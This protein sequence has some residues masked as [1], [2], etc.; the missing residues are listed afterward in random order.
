MS[1]DKCQVPHP[2]FLQP[3][4]YGWEAKEETLYC[5]ACST[6]LV[7][8]NEKGA[9]G[10]IHTEYTEGDEWCYVG[11]HSSKPIP[12]DDR[13]IRTKKI[14]YLCIEQVGYEEGDDFQDLVN[15]ELSAEKQAD[16]ESLDIM[17]PTDFPTDFSYRMINLTKLKL[18]CVALEKLI[19]TPY[20]TPHLVIVELLE[21]GD[22]KIEFDVKLPKL[23]EFSLTKV[24]PENGCAD[25]NR[26]IAAAPH[27]RDFELVKMNGPG[28]LVITSSN[29]LKNLDLRGIDGVNNV[30]IYAPNLKCLS[31]DGSKYLEKIVLQ[32]C[33]STLSE[34]LPIGHVATM[35]DC[36]GNYSSIRTRNWLRDCPRAI[37]KDFLPERE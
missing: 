8:K 9:D 33:H 7:R 17:G 25:L 27:L 5:H 4:E 31:F 16:I 3:G 21:C 23:E 11:P 22:D 32:E 1:K 6:R 35:F 20:L 26:M 14:V 30:T 24:E 37:I 15:H 29:Y 12:E 2:F 36:Y 10:L 34:K 13:R 18:T 28:E 19:L